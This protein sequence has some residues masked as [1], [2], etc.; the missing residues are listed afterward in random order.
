MWSKAGRREV[1][2]IVKPRTSNVTLGM[3]EEA[4]F[5]DV[6]ETSAL[7]AFCHLTPGEAY[8]DQ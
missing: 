2:R 5:A 6:Q 1:R 8:R 7:A 4:I 3:T